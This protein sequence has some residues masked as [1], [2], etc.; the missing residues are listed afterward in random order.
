MEMGVG[1]H[2]EPGRKRMPLKAADEI[3]EILSDAIITDLP[4]KSGDEV[5]ALVNGLGGTPLVELYVV[6]NK[7]A[8]ICSKKGIKIARNLVGNYVTSLDMAGCSITLVKLDYNL[9]KLWDYPVNT[10]ALRWGV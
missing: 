9:T 1:V 5:W 10:F 7:L 2:G 4:Y 3:V 8:D 6:Y